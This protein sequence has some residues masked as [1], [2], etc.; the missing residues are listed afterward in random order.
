MLSTQLMISDGWDYSV[1]NTIDNSWE[2]TRFN[3]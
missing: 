1:V 2:I 3:E